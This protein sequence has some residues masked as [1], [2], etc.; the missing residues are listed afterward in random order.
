M[1]LNYTALFAD[2]D[3][4]T[5]STSLAVHDI[6]RHLRLNIGRR[7]LFKISRIKTIKDILEALT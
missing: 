4:H 1:L 6:I 5:I 2:A 3:I 7:I